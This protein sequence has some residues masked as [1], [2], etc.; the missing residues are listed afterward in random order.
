M[1]SRSI[2]L[3]Q[4][5]YCDLAIKSL[6]IMKHAPELIRTSNPVDRS[7]AR[8]RSTTVSDPNALITRQSEM[9]N[10]SPRHMP[11]L[12]NVHPIKKKIK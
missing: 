3:V 5:L 12:G 7:P 8:Y 11:V 1:L 4:S 6:L 9:A 2:D 10:T